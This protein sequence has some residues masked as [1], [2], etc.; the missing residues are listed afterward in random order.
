MAKTKATDPRFS[1]G[2]D[3][4]ANKPRK[5]SAEGRAGGST[6]RSRK[7]HAESD[8]KNQYAKPV[9]VLKAT[10]ARVD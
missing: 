10:G 6:E 8:R 7:L 1:A 5:S 9:R 3:T 2:K 4:G